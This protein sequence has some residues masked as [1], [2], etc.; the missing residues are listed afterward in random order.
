MRFSSRVLFAVIFLIPAFAATNHAFGAYTA[1]QIASNFTLREF[2]TS[3]YVSLY[4]FEDHIIVLDFF[5]YSCGPCQVA[6]S[7]LEP[8]IQQYYD[9]RG[10]NPDGIPVQLISISISNS[11]PDYV[12]AYKDYFGLDL[13][14]EANASTYY[15]YS[16]G[17]IPQFAI[18]NGVEDGNYD[19]WEILN[20]Q[21]G[22]GSGL[23]AVFRN[24]INLVEQNDP[25][26]RPG[27]LNGDGT[28]SAADLDI[29]R[30]NW[31]V[32]VEAGSLISGDASGDG[33]V[34]AADLDIVRANWGAHAAAAVP[35]PGIGVLLLVAMTAVFTR[36]SSGS[37]C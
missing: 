13:V 8:Y 2:G 14:L 15:Q 4:D 12:Q 25:V 28:V 19:Q 30:A 5:S 10:G 18:I 9:A 35:E 31:G 7:E 24:Y 26:V 32:Q 11:Y 34:S 29:V 23:Y 22:Y 33:L 16:T 3:N 21:T 1:G 17:S 36:R 6:S 20:M 27:D 37:R